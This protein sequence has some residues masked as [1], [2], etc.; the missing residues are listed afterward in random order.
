MSDNRELFER[1]AIGQ[2]STLMTYEGFCAA[3]RELAATDALPTGMEIHNR[4]CG[5]DG[6]LCQ[7][8][9]LINER[10][11]FKSEIAKL[12]EPKNA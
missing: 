11:S 4:F 10:S 5:E 3:L 2:L 1:Y 9:K 12:Q 7:A 6:H 8:H